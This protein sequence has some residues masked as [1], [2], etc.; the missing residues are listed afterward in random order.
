V[1]RK[2]PEFYK[3]FGQVAHTPHYGNIL[4]VR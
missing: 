2:Y 1:N 4:A 3:Q